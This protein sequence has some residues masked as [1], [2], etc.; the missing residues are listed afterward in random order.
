VVLISLTGQHFA[1]AAR[2]LAPFDPVV[3]RRAV[4]AHGDYTLHAWL[5]KLRRT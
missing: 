5:I 1:E 4:F 3:V 2:S